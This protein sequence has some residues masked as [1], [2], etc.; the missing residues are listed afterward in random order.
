MSNHPLRLLVVL[1]ALVLTSCS[2]NDEFELVENNT[3]TIT[4]FSEKEIEIDILNLI[5][6][7]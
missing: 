7:F 4:T 6:F 2:A 3:E 1:C 5:N